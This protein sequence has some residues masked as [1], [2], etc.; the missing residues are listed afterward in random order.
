MP[1]H[2]WSPPVTQRN[3]QVRPFSS[4]SWRLSAETA[5]ATFLGADERNA[6]IDDHYI[7]KI[8]MRR[9][10]NLV[11]LADQLLGFGTSSRDKSSV[12]RESVSAGF[13]GRRTLSLIAHRGRR[14]GKFDF[15]VSNGI[16][17]EQIKTSRIS[18]RGK[19][20]WLRTA[21]KKL[22]CAIRRL[23]PS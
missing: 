4:L 11:A 1:S 14:Y 23:T 6:R 7:V 8:A 13:A 2:G 3:Q 19:V 5:S 18:A 10:Q 9:C 22:Q 15:D 12:L 20:S 17:A 16:L 21:Q